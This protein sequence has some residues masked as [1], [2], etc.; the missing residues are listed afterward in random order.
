[1]RKRDPGH[2]NIERWLVSYAD[3]ITLL[4]AFFVVMYAISQA[5]MA[6]FKAVAGS[7]KAAF[8][9]AAAG[10]AVS[11]QGQSG[12]PTV[13]PFEEVSVRG[14][15]VTDMPA[16]K[17][18]TAADPDAG[19][20]ELRELL[21]ESLTLELGVASSSDILHTQFDSRGLILRLSVND[22]FDVGSFEVRPDLRPV[23]DRIGRTLAG[24]KR[25]IRVE[26]HTDITET[27]APGAPGSWEL[28][29]AR[30]AWVVKYWLKRFEMDPRRI[31][32]AGYAHFRPIGDSRT[33]LGKARNRRVEIIVLNNRYESP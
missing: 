28:S 1:M 18:N 9:A 32:I 16:G 23:L 7:L 24:T 17:F 25:L 13:A 30:A 2:V 11:L 8:G 29:A 4:F 5:D 19:L 6:K 31:G 27:Q 3:F 15:R 10:G 14:G 21:E 12:G 22:F 26:G 20:Q 33:V